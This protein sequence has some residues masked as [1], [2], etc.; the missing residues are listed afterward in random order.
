MNEPAPDSR[1]LASGLPDPSW[2]A[3][4]AE[5]SLRSR[6]QWNAS[7]QR[8]N[9]WRIGGQARCLVD[10]AEPEDLAKLLPFIA[11]Y[12]VP[13]TL[14]GKGSNL[15]IPDETWP[16][17]VIHLSGSFKHWVPSVEARTVQAGAALADVTF[18]QRCVELG[19]G[20]MEFLVGVPGTIGGA[21]AMNAGA[22]GGEVS[23]FLSQA[24]WFDMRGQEHVASSEQAGFRYRHS[25]LNGRNGV[26]VTSATFELRESEPAQ[27]RERLSQCLRF[28]EDKQPRQPSCGSVFKNPPGDHAAR[29]IEHSGLKGFCVGDAQVSLKHTNFIVNLGSARSADLEAV[30]R[31]VQR[32]VFEQHG[33]SLEPEVQWLQPLPSETLPLLD[34]P[35]TMSPKWV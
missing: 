18:S 7:L 19:W 30:I 16:G 5:L 28:R 8:L 27:V 9:T 22:H 3:A 29:L 31:E 2:K 33:V 10:V 34:E 13:W 20:G 23:D 17:I 11:E 26:V 35:E 25:H 4:F 1:K 32:R 15:L 14:L 24:R 12:Q 21:V 6:V